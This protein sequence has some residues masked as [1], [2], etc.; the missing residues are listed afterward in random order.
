MKTDQDDN[1]EIH[2]L[3]IDYTDVEDKPERRLQWSVVP[4]INLGIVC[5][6]LAALMMV[7]AITAGASAARC[8]AIM[9][10]AWQTPRINDHNQ[11]LE[12]R[13]PN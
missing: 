12:C 1:T 10:T 13:P 3:D 9:N 2:P 4:A 5:F 11:T 6:A 7:I 8:S